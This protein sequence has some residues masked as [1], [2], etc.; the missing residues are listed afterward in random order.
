MSP[1]RRKKPAPAGRPAG[2]PLQERKQQLVREAIRNAALDLFLEQG[3]GQTRIEDIA[4]RA[5]VSRRTFF[6]YFASRDDLLGQGVDQF[7][8]IV[9]SAL[10]SSPERCTPMELFRQTVAEV[11]R[12]SAAD[13]RARDVVRLT[14]QSPAA[15]AAQHARIMPVEELL[16]EAFRA[17]CGRNAAARAAAPVFAAMTLAAVGAAMRLWCLEEKIDAAEAAAR[18]VAAF[19]R[20]VSD[21]PRPRPA[22]FV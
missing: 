12:R 1:P 20:L 11:V 15:R 22:R 3:F 9:R 4:A 13:P 21:S 14:M 8:E 7:R 16:E 18:V 19:E 17:R 6:R 5:G 2:R 10:A